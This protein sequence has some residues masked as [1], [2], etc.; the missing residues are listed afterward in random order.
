MNSMPVDQKLFNVVRDLLVAERTLTAKTATAIIIL[1]DVDDAIDGL[2]SGGVAEIEEYE[3][4]LLL[5]PL[6]TPSNDDRAMCEAALSPSGITAETCNELYLQLSKEKLSCPVVYGL[7]SGSMAIPDII[8]ERYIRLLGLTS[9]VSQN[10]A[11]LLETV[12]DSENRDHAFCLARRPVWSNSKSC[13]VL[14][15]CL[16]KM[17]EKN[18]FSLNK[19]DFLTA[20]VRTYRPTAE[21]ILLTNLN[22]MVTAYHQDK[23][24]PVYNR[25]LAKKQEKSLMPLSCNKEIRANRIAMAYEILGDFNL[26]TINKEELLSVN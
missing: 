1:L 11:E 2:D 8:I 21:D 7:N 16:E 26:E 6:F 25:N 4:E 12:V 24:H 10:I 5:S 14:A 17:H 19:M 22:N 23:D 9:E 15:I 20:F 18:S 13:D 3:A